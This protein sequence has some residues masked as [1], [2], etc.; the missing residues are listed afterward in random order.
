MTA[1]KIRTTQSDLAL[2][3]T[4]GH[5]LTS[6][7]SAWTSAA[8]SGGSKFI[9]NGRLTL[10][11]GVAI[12]TTNQ[13][14]KITLYFTP[15][16]GNQIGL[17]DGVSAWNIV[18]FAQLSLNISAF[19]A[20]KPYDIWVYNNAGT[21]TLDSTVWTSG[22]ARATEL[23]LQDGVYVKT[24]ATT[25]RYVGTI[26]MDAASKC[27]DTEEKRYCWNYYNGV[28]RKLYKHDNTDSWTYAV[29]SWR[30]WRATA[31]NQVEFIIGLNELPVYFLVNG[32]GRN[33]AAEC[34][35]S[36]GVGLDQTTANS[37]DYSLSGNGAASN[38]FSN[39]F[40]LYNNLAGVGFHYLAMLE[41]AQVATVTFVGD[42]GSTLQKTSG[43][44][45]VVG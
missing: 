36:I 38:Y 14:D 16:Q 45:W 9:S 17:Y 6:N 30:Q 25:R 4:S 44:G 18:S 11:T 1:T 39:S 13:V 19:T 8:A 24:G 10:E 35:F 32:A 23:A 21:A 22:T 31:T 2:P 26:Y 40:S 3:S 15:Y 12:S 41:L 42:F 20:S 29:A 33:A 27:Q 37:G 7:G 43:T 34:Y 28:N 5:V